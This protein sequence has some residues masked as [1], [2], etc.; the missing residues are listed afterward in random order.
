[1]SLI[2]EI[3]SDTDLNDIEEVFNEKQSKISWL[4]ICNAIKHE[5]YPKLASAIRPIIREQNE[6]KDNVDD[7]E[8]KNTLKIGLYDIEENVEKVIEYLKTKRKL[9]VE[10][11]DYLKKLIKR[12][13]SHD[14]S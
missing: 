7:D 11:R 2:D 6:D 4:N 1:M 10:E 9:G 3:F 5:M 8:N 14:Q 13:I 12:A